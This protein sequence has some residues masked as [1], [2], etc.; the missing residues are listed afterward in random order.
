MEILH[1][2][3]LF[4]FSHIILLHQAES[5]NFKDSHLLVG[6]RCYY[7]NTEQHYWRKFRIGFWLFV[8]LNI[9]LAFVLELMLVMIG[10]QSYSHFQCFQW[11]I[12]FRI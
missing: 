5:S 4:T 2:I 3:Q 7:D 1:L 10:I 6:C 9:E 8:V 11:E 12:L